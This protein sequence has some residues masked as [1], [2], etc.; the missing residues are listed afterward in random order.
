MSGLFRGALC[1]LASLLVCLLARGF[2]AHT[3]KISVQKPVQKILTREQKH[4]MKGHS[5]HFYETPIPF[6][7]KRGPLKATPRLKDSAAIDAVANIKRRYQAAL[8]RA[9]LDPSPEHIDAIQG[10]QLAVIQQAA[11]FQR[12]WQ[13]RYLE[14]LPRFTSL[15][16]LMS[17]Y[18]QG[19]QSRLNDADFQRAVT[20]FN[21]TCGLIYFY[22]GQCPYCQVFE[23]VLKNFV[24]RYGLTLK[25]VSCDG[26]A[27]TIFPQPKIHPPDLCQRFQITH[28]PSVLIVRPKTQQQAFLSVGVLSQDQLKQHL[29]WY[30]NEAFK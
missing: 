27:H 26:S 21:A 25:A 11:R 12:A 7:F 17:D 4:P 2:G 29:S 1:C 20:R 30:L 5:W 28:T 8:D 13:I 3:P 16:P 9:I 22:K 6:K 19:Y 23:P 24:R 14:N 15:V 10:L 18:A